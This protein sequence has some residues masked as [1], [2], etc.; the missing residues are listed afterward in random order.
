VTPRRKGKLD[1]DVTETPPE[2]LPYSLS[3]KSQN[4]FS[5][6]RDLVRLVDAWPALP[7]AIRR[8]ILALVE[9]SRMA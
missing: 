4:P 1:K 8:A 2:T 3:R 9:S 5:K 7:E 6:D